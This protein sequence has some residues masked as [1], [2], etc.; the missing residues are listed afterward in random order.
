MAELFKKHNIIKNREI[1]GNNAPILQIILSAT[2]WTTEMNN[3]VPVTMYKPYICIASLTE[4]IVFKQQIVY[5]E[6]CKVESRLK[7][8]LVSGEKNYHINM[9]SL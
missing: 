8:H 5:L 3:F 7:T 6:L 1:Q 4:A 9:C 2:Y